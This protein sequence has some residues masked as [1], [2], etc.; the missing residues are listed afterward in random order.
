MR[1][2]ALA[3][4]LAPCAAASQT[5]ERFEFSEPH[6][7]TEFRV[8]LY[9]RAAAEAEAAAEAAFTVAG[10][11]DSLFS[12]YRDDSEI[13]AIARQAGSGLWYPASDELRALLRPVLELAEKSGGAFD[14]TVGPLTRLWR[15]SSRRGELPDSARLAEARALVGYEGLEVSSE[16]VRLARA[17]MSLDLGGVAKGYA[18]DVMLS[19]ITSTCAD[20]PGGRS[21]TVA[22]V[23]AGGDIRV[24]E[25]PPGASGWTV[26]TP[27]GETLPLQFEA[28]A[29]SGDAWRYI[30]IDGVRYSHIV[31]PRTGVGVVDANP[32]T[33]VAPYGFLADA[34]ASA[35]SVMDRE[36]GDRLL[37][38]FNARRIELEG[39][40]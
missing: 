9:A 7:G 4:L 18:A 22:M 28:V 6:M 32:V 40:H 13:A 14:P 12:D 31:D 2:V 38:R 15:W 25:A 29:T 39:A 20:V 21:C 1:W 17:G 35:L 26:A 19:T 30:E 5:L 27:G 33:V 8:V 34:L 24:G 36:A 23:D 11:L 16:G 37:A 10:R 3:A